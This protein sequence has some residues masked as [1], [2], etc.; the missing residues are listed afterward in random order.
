[1]RV[2]KWKVRFVSSARENPKHV[3]PKRRHICT[4]TRIFVWSIYIYLSRYVSQFQ[5]MTEAA[6]STET[7][8]HIYQTTFMYL[9]MR[10]QVSLKRQWQC[11]RLFQFCYF[12]DGRSRSLRHGVTHLTVYVGSSTV[13]IQAEG[14][15]ETSAHVHYTIR[16]YFTLKMKAA[17]CC[18]AS[19]YIRQT[20]LVCTDCVRNVDNNLPDLTASCMR[21]SNPTS[22][23]CLCIFRLQS[24]PSICFQTPSTYVAFKS[25]RLSFGTCTKHRVWVLPRMNTFWMSVYYHL[26]SPTSLQSSSL[27]QLL[28]HEDLAP[29]GYRSGNILESLSKGADFEWQAILRPPS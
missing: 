16:L 19:V 1:M 2:S 11:D 28:S 18:E 3:R 20:A 10:K 25:L 22:G 14:F 24:A 27:L 23:S 8:A 12:Y 6:H 9:V 17:D 26:P 4:S 13:M 15:F 5:L 7:S 29:A 21:I